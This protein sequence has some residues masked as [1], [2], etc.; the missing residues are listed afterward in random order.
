MMSTE[1]RAAGLGSNRTPDIYR[2]NPIDRLSSRTGI[3]GIP[4]RA[5]AMFK[6]LAYDPIAVT[7]M[8]FGILLTAALAFVF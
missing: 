7:I 4:W 1:V 5:F 3:L 2:G 6:L 8:G